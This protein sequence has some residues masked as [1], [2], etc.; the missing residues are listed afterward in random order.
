[1]EFKTWWKQGQ[2]IPTHLLNNASMLEATETPAK[3]A[4]QKQETLYGH[5]NTAKQFL[6]DFHVTGDQLFCDFCQHNADWKHV[7]MYKDHLQSKAMTPR[8]TAKG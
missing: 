2:I 5:Q 3:S 6:K 7:D 1:M 4:K 8:S